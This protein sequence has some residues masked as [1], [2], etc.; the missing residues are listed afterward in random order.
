MLTAIKNLFELQNT[1]FENLNLIQLIHFP[2]WK[3]IVNNTLK[4][5]TLDHLYVQDPTIITDVTSKEPLCGDHVIV[6][7]QIKG[8]PDPP[9]V[10]LKR[11]WQHYTAEKL[12]QA[13]LNVTFN[14]EADQVQAY[15][16][17][18]EAIILP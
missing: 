8:T 4:E 5:S 15:W 14:I 6:M 2:T 1:F 3:R 11:N 16:N 12:N 9:S 17:K 7:F 18:F 10:F 13:L